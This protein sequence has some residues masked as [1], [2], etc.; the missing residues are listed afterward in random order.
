MIMEELEPGLGMG[1]T[2]QELW[3]C[4]DVIEHHLNS[5]VLDEYQ[6]HVHNL[7]NNAHSHAVSPMPHLKD[8]VGTANR[9]FKPAVSIPYHMVACVLTTDI[10][11]PDLAPLQAIE[12]CRTQTGL[13]KEHYRRPECFQAATG[14]TSHR[15]WWKILAG[16]AVVDGKLIVEYDRLGLPCQLRR[17]AGRPRG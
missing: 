10:L 2:T 3:C 13:K 15:G 6:T 17:L 7:T 8:F 4:L 12:E 14:V 16:T 5:G 9:W 11:K 1:G